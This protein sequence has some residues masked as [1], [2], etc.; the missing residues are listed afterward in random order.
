MHGTS[1]ESGS[2][3]ASVIRSCSQCGRMNRIPARHL[4]HSGRCGN[5]KRELPPLAEPIE[6]D[7]A[8]LDAVRSQAS[9]PLLVDF[10]AAWCG[11]CRVMAPE[12]EKL[13]ASH[14]GQLLV[15]KVDTERHPEL[16]S[17]YT[18]EALPT[19][20]MFRAGQ[21][22]ERLAGARTAAALARE[23]SL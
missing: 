14:A 15:G 11:P 2:G 12:L 10:W 4:A 7:A 22:R 20:V 8:L 1:V 9:V 5:C 16:A 13:A 23:L 19:L 3:N 18:I 21:P 6:L 17:R